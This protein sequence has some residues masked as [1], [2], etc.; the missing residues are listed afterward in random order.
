MPELGL[1]NMPEIPPGFQ[2]V[3]ESAGL[4]LVDVTL[5][6]IKR[7]ME[8]RPMSPEL[9]TLLKAQTKRGVTDEVSLSGLDKRWRHLLDLPAPATPINSDLQK[10][11]D[12][13]E[14]K[15]LRA[16]STL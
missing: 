16:I 2:P 13:N 9:K 7:S 6:A 1:A 4:E 11:L 12:E 3:G 15:R 8:G 10:V 14:A 5:W